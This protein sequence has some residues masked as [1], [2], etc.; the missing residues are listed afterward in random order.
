MT[1]TSHHAHGSRRAPF[2]VARSLAVPVLLVLFTLFA[3]AA[4][5]A[6]EEEAQTHFCG[7]DNCFD[8]LGLQRNASKADVRRAFRRLSVSMH[9]DKRPDDPSAIQKFRKINTAHTVL[10]D[11]AHRRKYEDFL[12]NPTKYWDILVALS[13]EH[14]APKSNVAFVM[15]G[16]L[17]IATLIHWLNMKNEYRRTLSKMKES[18]EFKREVTRLVKSKKASNREEAEAM[19]NL[20]VVGLEEPDWRNLIVFRIAR[21]PS[22]VGKAAMW[23][24]RW[25][26]NYKIRKLEFS[27]DDKLYLIQKNMSKSDEEWAAI[28][29]AD[30]AKYVEKDLWDMEKC[31][32]YERL[33]RIQLNRMGKGAKKKKHAPVPYSEAEEVVMSE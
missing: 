17:G 30:K 29:D 33:E 28:S 10:T 4:P 7:Q 22:H 20:D 23:N 13:K 24:A 16:L 8:L 11:D 19:I 9:P 18:Q 6:A 15:A 12:D 26:F 3:L 31:K 27:N 25:F 14:Y 21:A 32:E 5:A 1:S 2:V